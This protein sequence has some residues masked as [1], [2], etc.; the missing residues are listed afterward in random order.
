MQNITY[1]GIKRGKCNNVK[2]DQKQPLQVRRRFLSVPNLSNLVSTIQ[3]MI[4]SF[5]VDFS[6]SYG[7]ATN[8]II[9]PPNIVAFTDSGF[10]INTNNMQVNVPC[11]IVFDGSTYAIWKNESESLVMLE[12]GYDQNQTAK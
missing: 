8:N 1:L 5:V 12:I 10:N 9:N 4:Q 2:R 11:I 7:I 6:N 3:V